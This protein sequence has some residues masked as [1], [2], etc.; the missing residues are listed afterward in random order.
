M[1][2]WLRPNM[3]DYDEDDPTTWPEGP[4]KD[5]AVNLKAW[6]EWEACEEYEE[7]PDYVPEKAEALALMKELDEV[8]DWI[9]KQPLEV[10]RENKDPEFLK[11]D[12]RA[13][14]IEERL[15]EIDRS[16]KSRMP[17]NAERR[18][19]ALLEAESKEAEREFDLYAEVA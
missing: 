14:E 18:L 19:E 6:I 16:P 11:H 15:E 3:P 12:K 2:E 8:S 5:E 9:G 17:K 1:A 13:N 7:L 10:L 4:A